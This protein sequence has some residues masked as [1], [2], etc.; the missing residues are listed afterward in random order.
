MADAPSRAQKYRVDMN[1]QVSYTVKFLEHIMGEVHVQLQRLERQAADSDLAAVLTSVLFVYQDI[2]VEAMHQRER[3]PALLENPE[4]DVMLDA[5]NLLGSLIER[6][7]HMRQSLDALL[8][9]SA[10][11]QLQ[12]EGL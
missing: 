6:F 5:M 7:G 3:L 9:L 2:E 8:A 4:I 11:P 12:S 10:P 1:I